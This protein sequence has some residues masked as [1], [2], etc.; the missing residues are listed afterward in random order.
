MF[1]ASFH[2]NF[3]FVVLAWPVS[4]KHL[5]MSLRTLSNQ[6]SVPQPITLYT[7]TFTWSSHIAAALLFLACSGRETATRRNVTCSLVNTGQPLNSKE[8]L[9]FILCVCSCINI[10]SLFTNSKVL[11]K[12]TSVVSLAFTCQNHRQTKA[13]SPLGY[14]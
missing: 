1:F 2:T 3:Y 13:A 11:A 9:A 10:V 14:N 7:D 5:Y 4:M 12:A 6:K 8:T